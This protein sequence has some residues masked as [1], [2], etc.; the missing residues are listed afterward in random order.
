M[1][2][3][4]NILNP[5]SGQVMKK[6]GMKFEGI[7]RKARKDNK[8]EFFDIAQYALLKTDLE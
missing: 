8:G 5:A 7:L 2:F 1:W 6:C 3:H 4:K